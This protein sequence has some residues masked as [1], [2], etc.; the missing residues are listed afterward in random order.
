MTLGSVATT[1]EVARFLRGTINQADR[2][3]PGVP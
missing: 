3:P 2:R 1:F